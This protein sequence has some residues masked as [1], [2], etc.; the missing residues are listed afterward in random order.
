MIHMTTGF[1]QY[2]S[3]GKTLLITAELHVW[4]ESFIVQEEEEEEARRLTELALF[5]FA[6]F[7][8]GLF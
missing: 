1:P 8:D 4:M 6:Q 2:C 3:D 7:G 5:F